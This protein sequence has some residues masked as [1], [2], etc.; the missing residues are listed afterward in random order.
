MRLLT[1]QTSGPSSSSTPCFPFLNVRISVLLLSIF[2]LFG[3]SACGDGS[4]NTKRTP[5][6][7]NNVQGDTGYSDVGDDTPDTSPGLGDTDLEDTDLRDTQPDTAEEK[8]LSDEQE[9][10][11]PDP[12]TDPSDPTCN[13]M[14]IAGEICVAGTC[15]DDTAARKCGDAQNLGQLKHGATT[16][17]SGTLRRASD[18]IATACGPDQTASNV[19]A[20]AVFKFTVEQDSR[21][22]FKARW[23]GEFD[24]VIA[25]HTDSC[26][27][28]G[29]SMDACFDHE[30]QSLH[31]LAGHDYYMIVELSVGRGH[32]FTV[33]LTAQPVDCIP[34]SDAANT[35]SDGTFYR[36][37]GAGESVAYDCAANCNG[38][39]T[40]C[41][42]NS[43]A[44]PIVV[45]ASTTF[46]G[47]VQSYDSKYDFQFI[48]GCEV[49][50]TAVPTAG[51]EVIFM[52]PNLTA[53]QTVTVDAQTNDLNSNAIFITSNCGTPT[54]L[55]CVAATYG[56]EERLIWTVP[57]DGR[58]FVFI[59]KDTGA[60]NAFEYSIDIQ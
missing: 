21:I 31:A 50:D 5:V 24:G 56:G 47:N 44:E 12:D 16:T 45:T 38:A 29:S 58:Y 49:E 13:D 35:C 7:V 19:G 27:I 43:C 22:D 14:C 4:D 8:D 25:F 46:S 26:E 59:D 11:T 20:E 32:D 54:E 17:A 10:V 23:L 39:G 28:P 1:H 6:P 40:E 2:V 42:G 51:Q 34:G 30:E 9:D 53:G 36:C 15:I 60:G 48:A 3:Q 41:L 55:T 33:E 18:V 52:L 57:A 37:E